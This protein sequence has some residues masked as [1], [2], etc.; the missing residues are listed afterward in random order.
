MNRRRF[1]A[2]AAA[3]AAATPAAAAVGPEA[4]MLSSTLDGAE[5]GV[6]PARANSQ[7]RGLQRLLEVASDDNRELFLPAGTYMVSELKL[8]PR[9]RLAGVPGATRLVFGGGEFMMAGER[10]ALV[11][12]RD[13][14]I[15]GAGQPMA[16]YVP[17]LVHLTEAP[18]VTIANCIITGST[19]AGL[20]LDRSGGSITRTTV[21][22]AAD[23]GIR[24][25]EATG[26][27]LTD[28]IVED[29]GN[30]GILVHRW[31][32]REDGT[33]VT[34]NRVHRVGYADIGDGPNGCG[35][36]VFRADG[37]ILANNRIADCA[38]HTIR[39]RSA[40]NVQVTGN[41]CSGAADAGIRADMDFAGIVIASNIVNR[42]ATGVSL[43]SRGGDSRSAIV[44]GN[45][46]RDI[47][48]PA[49]AEG[50]DAD[51]TAGVGIA[52]EAD[53][54]LTGNVVETADKA[55]LWIGRSA[56]SGDVAATGNFIRGAPVGIAVSVA[57][58]AGSA[59]ISDNLISGAEKGAILAMRGGEAVSGD[60]VRGGAGRYPHL[61]VERN[62]TA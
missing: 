44:S 34:G 40:A 7:S 37:V 2:G 19:R 29:C 60:L 12:L 46:V 49:P 38:R 47:V 14:T 48:A 41:N 17:G 36:S 57:G 25:L 13:L 3:F 58:G 53:V 22:N 32:A 59:V 31:S 33:I 4:P 61:T 28:N 9:T 15:D 1:L 11:S 10:L 52:V 24:A 55:G 39:V 30:G 54:A 26:L 5:L 20:A 21:R 16:D 8:P 45:L 43:A 56:A 27:S 62:R 23:A 42:A 6:D 51:P 50:A 18:N 35:I